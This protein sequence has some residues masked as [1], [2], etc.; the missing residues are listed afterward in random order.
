M[1]K[2]IDI[3]KFG[4]F[5]DYSWNSEIGSDP[6]KHSFKK[7]NIIYG[8]NYSGKTTLSRIFRCVE[9]EEIHKDYPDAKFTISTDDDGTII[10]ES[11]LTYSK[12]IRVYN[13]DFVK[14]NLSWLHNEEGEILP[15]TLLGGDNTFIEGKIKDID[16]QLGV[17]DEE[18]NSY[19]KGS[20]YSDKNRKKIEKE[21]DDKK[22]KSLAD[23]LTQ[24]LTE[25]ANYDI[26]INP[27]FARQ[28]DFY[29]ITKIK[30]DIQDII[31]NNLTS[32]LTEKEVDKQKD[33][34]NEVR[35][36]PISIVPSISLNF[37]DYV[38]ASKKL[39]SKK[40]TLTNTLAELIENDLLQDWVDKGR[41]LH[42][43][44]E[45]CGFCGSPI[46][47]QRRKKIDEHFSKESEELKECIKNTLNQLN[48]FRSEINNYLTA[49]N[50]K[51]DGFYT[52]LLAEFTTIE[53]KWNKAIETQNSQIDIL[54]KKLEERLQN[55]FIPL[56]EIDF[57]EIE[58]KPVDLNSIINELNVL[59]GKNEDKSKS[60]EEDKNIARK[61][62]RYNAIIKFL[63]DIKYTSLVKAI[64]E[65]KI[66]AEVSSENYEKIKITI[67]KLEA[68]KANL[69]KE[70][71]DESK[72]AEKINKHL[73]DFF[74]VD[75]LK[76]EPSE[77]QIDEE[78]KTRFVVKRSNQE[79]K[80]LSEGECSLIAFCYF[81]AK[82]EDELKDI[83]AKDNLIV[84]ID[85]PISSLDNNHIFF[86]FGLI[87][88]IIT[89]TKNYNQL[90]I[91]THNLEF[92]RY[93]KRLTVP[94]DKI[95]KGDGKETS[96]K[97]WNHYLIYKNKNDSISQSHMRYMP[98]YLSTYTTEYNFLF[99]QIYKMALP[100]ENKI[101]LYENEYSLLYNL[102]NNMR[103]FLE[104]FLFY[105]YPDT[106]NPLNDYLSKLFDGAIHPRV[107]RII[108]EYSHL[109][110]GER[111]TIPEDIA[112]A[113]ETAQLILRAVKS[114]DFEHFKALCKSIKVDHNIEL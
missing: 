48:S 92:L 41:D 23:D 71:K 98:K 22:A 82:I 5:F 17:N 63:N 45:T 72:A 32:T 91:S 13:T 14:D 53:K 65:A 79:A 29:N 19:K 109:T 86:M 20:L 93:L 104:C 84:Y 73:T 101:N 99:G 77:Q 33:I 68:E 76:L 8:R 21:N 30:K 75:G 80:N 15:F 31:N 10:N 106:H 42:K 113:E 6:D 34:I 100:D 94:F 66:K 11:N 12:N 89:K 47:L 70:L 40:I 88:S 78:V 49:N 69:E 55:I 35:K 87:E 38:V 4:L 3:Q 2:K 110:W 61:S 81:M 74:G 90:F 25:K 64:D 1:I 52:V 54:E 18:T 26:K 36:N 16:N 24:R 43:D 58:E 83:K 114:K 108:N 107:N 112:E 27:L 97:S 7:V 67:S 46:T 56:T 85:D 105:K 103:K 96:Q 60:I 95:M 44:R 9:K 59:I 28:V 57:S 102:P 51:S 50:V 39:L 37:L 111:G 62:L